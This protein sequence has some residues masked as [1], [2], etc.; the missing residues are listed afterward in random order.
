M[1]DSIKEIYIQV[2]LFDLVSHLSFVVDRSPLI[3]IYVGTK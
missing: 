2:A 1:L 3:Q